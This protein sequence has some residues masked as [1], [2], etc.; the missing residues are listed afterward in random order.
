MTIILIVLDNGLRSYNMNF[1]DVIEINR[2]GTTS[3]NTCGDSRLRG[4]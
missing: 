4:L 1:C 3:N 2:A